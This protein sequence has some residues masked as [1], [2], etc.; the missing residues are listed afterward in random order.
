MCGEKS[1][2]HIML[3]LATW[4]LSS[5]KMTATPSRQSHMSYVKP[6]Q[7]FPHWRVFVSL[8]AT[9]LVCSTHSNCFSETNQKASGIFPLRFKLGTYHQRPFLN[10]VTLKW[11]SF[12]MVQKS[13][14]ERNQLQFTPIFLSWTDMPYTCWLTTLELCCGDFPGML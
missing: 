2:N 3:D 5:C 14:W 11:I 6:L 1:I 13:A 10:A 4:R 9:Q 7:R 8:S 12:L